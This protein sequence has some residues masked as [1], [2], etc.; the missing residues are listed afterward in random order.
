M[1]KMLTVLVHRISNSQVIL[2]K[3]KKK[4]YSHSFSK[5]SSIYTILIDQSFNDTL[6]NDIVSFEQM[7]PEM[8]I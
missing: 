2:L 4:S 5:N 1:V 7:G 3:K 8:F 6:T